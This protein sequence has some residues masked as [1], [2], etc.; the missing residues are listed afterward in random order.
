[1]NEAPKRDTDRTVEAARSIR[2]KLTSDAP[3]DFD[4]FAKPKTIEERL[5]EEAEDWDNGLDD[6]LIEAADALAAP[7]ARTTPDRDDA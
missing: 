6:L 7:R 5:R 3:R 4:T 2:A 1:V